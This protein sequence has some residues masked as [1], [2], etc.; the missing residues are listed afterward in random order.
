MNIVPG[1]PAE[2]AGF[3][4]GD[5]IV[6]FQG[7]S[8]RYTEELAKW[9]SQSPPKQSVEF[10]VSK[11]G[12]AISRTVRVNTKPWFKKRDEGKRR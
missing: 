9:V 5:T 2:R 3:C 4:I 7:R 10:T 6:S 1:G 8:V 12:S 11:G